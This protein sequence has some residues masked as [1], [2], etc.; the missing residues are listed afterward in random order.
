MLVAVCSSCNGEG[1]VLE[2]AVSLDSK[3][4]NNEQ[5]SASGS[6]TLTA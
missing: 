4:D 3:D 5:K 6:H 2:E 1:V